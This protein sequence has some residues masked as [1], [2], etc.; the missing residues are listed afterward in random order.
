M[1]WREVREADLEEC[2]KI[3]PRN[4]GDQIIGRDRAMAVWRG[5]VRSRSFNSCVIESSGPSGGIVAFGASLFVAEAYATREIESP[6][7]DLNSRIIAGIANGESIVRPEADLYQTNVQEP[8]DEVT[9]YGNWV[10]G[11]LN[12]EQLRE[13]QTLLPFL[14]VGYRLNRLFVE[15]IG[16]QCDFIASSGVWRVTSNF[17]DRR[18]QLAVMTC[19]EAFSVSGSLATSLFQFHEPILGLRDG[20]RHLLAEALTH[21]SDAELAKKM[22]L[23]PATIKKRWQALFEK[24][25]RVHSEILPIDDASG[26]SWARGPQKRHHVLAYVSS[27][28]QELRPYRWRVSKDA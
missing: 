7:P 1:K 13:V 21:R 24:I 20:E 6:R 8:L 26:P 11:V 4:L 17:A 10:D 23:S 19:S 14:Y 3:E 15:G 22:N 28:P 27:H 25:A 18:S 9:L 16:S 2:L 5:L 12:A